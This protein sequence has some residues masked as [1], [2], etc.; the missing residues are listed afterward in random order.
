MV[1]RVPP[2]MTHILKAA[3]KSK[4]P[5]TSIRTARCQSKISRFGSSR[6][7]NLIVCFYAYLTLC[8]FELLSMSCQHNLKKANYIQI[9]SRHYNSGL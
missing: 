4:M 7:V 3:K 9:T 2:Y 5:V 1:I 6:G 8:V